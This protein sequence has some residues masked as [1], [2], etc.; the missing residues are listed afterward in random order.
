DRLFKIRNCMNIEGV[1][2]QLPLFD[3]PIDP[4]MLVR[5]R[6]A[7]IDLSSALADLSAPLPYYRFTAMLQKSYALNQTVRGLG[8]ALLQALEK[9]DA[10]ALAVLRAGQEV[11]VLEAMRDTKQ[12]AIDEASAAEEATSHALEAVQQRQ[13][14]YQGLITAGLLAEE[15]Q[16]QA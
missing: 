3:P 14:Y 12:L 7:G 2:R 1:V 9:E 6:A 16:Q 11:S 8:A 10:E 5:A 4:G 13:D 15:R